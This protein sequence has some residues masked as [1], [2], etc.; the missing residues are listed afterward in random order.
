MPANGRFLRVAHTTGDG[1]QGGRGNAFGNIR[2]TGVAVSEFGV[3][4]LS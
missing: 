3:A 1:A 4:M 2:K